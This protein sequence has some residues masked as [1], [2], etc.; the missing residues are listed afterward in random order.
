MRLWAETAE[1][2]FAEGR[3]IAAALAERFDPQME[4]V[5][6]E[7]REKLEI[8][9]GVHSNAAGLRRWLEQRPPANAE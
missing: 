1:R 9:N 2:A 8:M 7:H 6:P 4:D 5:P 3:D